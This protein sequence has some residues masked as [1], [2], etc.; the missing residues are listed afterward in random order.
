MVSGARW[1]GRLAS[2]A[3][4]GTA[5]DLIGLTLIGALVRV[6]P[7]AVSDFPNYDGGMFLAMIGDIRANGMGLPD[8]ISYNGGAIPFNYPPLGFWIA[9]AL[10]MDPLWSLRLIPLVA[11]ILTVPVFYGLA[12]EL[13]PSRACASS[14][15]LIYAL[16]P[17]SWDHLLTGAGLTRA[18]GLLAA[19]IAI[20]LLVRVYRSGRPMEAAGAGI[21]AGLTALLHPE[22]AVFLAV[23]WGLVAIAFVRT[24]SAVTRTALAGVVAF[25]V[26]SPWLLY[27]TLSGRLAAV[28]SVAPLGVDAVSTTQSLLFLRLSDEVIFPVALLLAAVGL[29][30]LG[31]RHRWLVPAWLA[32]EVFLAARG[33]ATYASVP[34]ALAAGVGLAE[35]VA[36]DLLHRPLGSPG[37]AAA[38]RVATVVTGVWMILNVPL[39]MA[40]KQAPFDVVSAPS[41]EA[42]TWARSA[43]PTDARFAVVTG[44]TWYADIYSEWLPA[45]SDRV[46]LATM[47]G[48]EWLGASAWDARLDRYDALQKCVR[49]DA[50]CVSDWLSANATGSDNYVYVPRLDELNP[51]RL[52]IEAAPQFEVVFEN[53]GA[54]IAR[55]TGRNAT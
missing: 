33:A 13:L 29:L 49:S 55:W 52:A 51:L 25:A 34:L 38:M 1:R 6:V 42:M 17:R 30:V 32:V 9:A 21:A 18:T 50:L 12:R 7:S 27:L 41:R 8:F 31:N 14:A 26:V 22:A 40:L 19:M 37:Y 53:D 44:R 35:G 43:T 46:S 54:L 11:T 5:A 47:Q 48:Y 4:G 24:R 15:T 3:A 39:M 2:L 23:S 16:T 45:L 36:S 20:W 28:L 10:P